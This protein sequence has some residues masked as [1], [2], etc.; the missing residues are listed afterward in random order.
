MWA[1]DVAEGLCMHAPFGDREDC[2]SFVAALRELGICTYI[3]GV[4]FFGWWRCGV[5]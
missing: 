1:L 4:F 3:A 5:D 2:A